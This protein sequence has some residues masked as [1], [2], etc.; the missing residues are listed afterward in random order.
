MSEVKFGVGETVIDVETVATP[1]EEVKS[2]EPIPTAATGTVVRPSSTEFAGDFIPGFQDVI[3]KRLNIVQGVGQ[4]KDVHPQGA[5]VYGQQTVLFVP[6]KIDLQTGN[7][8][9]KGLPPVEITVLGFRL[10]P[11]VINGKTFKQP[12]RFVEKVAG[13]DRGA[14]C[15]SEEEVR[16]LGGT[17][18]YNE[19]NLKKDQGMKRFEHMAEAF[20]IIKRPAHLEADQA[21][22][23]FDIA[24]DKYAL[25]LWAM[26]GSAYT[27]A[28]KAVFFTERNMGCLHAA[29]Y[30]SWSFAVSTRSK[31]FAGNTFYVP[32][33]VPNK[34]SSPAFLA[35][36]KD[37][38]NPPAVPA[39]EEAQA[40]E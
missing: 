3:L 22:F 21:T 23:T 8:R 30:P 35:F 19:W 10:Y 28:A 39:G 26:K 1:V 27:A 11:V 13:G 17:T 40:A 33:C 7:I 14:I 20:C 12:Y 38:L 25:A 2:A 5:L 37:L 6:P 29:G 34:P 16:K 9:E 15:N 36:V 4:L 31:V 24:G 32:V 18:D